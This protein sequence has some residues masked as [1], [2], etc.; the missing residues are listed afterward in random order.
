M[1]RYLFNVA[2][3]PWWARAAVAALASLMIV[4]VLF[5]WGFPMIEPLLPFNEQTV[6]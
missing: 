1:V 6:G 5:R 3:G 4:A 2:P